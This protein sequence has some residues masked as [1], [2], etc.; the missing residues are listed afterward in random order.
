[1]SPKELKERTARFARDVTEFCTPLLEV[2]RAAIIADQLLRAGTAVNANYGSAQCGRSN[3]EFVA[4]LGQVVDDANESTGWLELLRDTSVVETTEQLER[5]V[6]ESLELTKIFAR[7]YN[8]AKQNQQ[9][10]KGT[11]KL[12]R[13]GGKKPMSR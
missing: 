8:T 11:E 13:A 10:R 1:M 12:R 5:L 9:L 3:D 7:S 4:K 2:R 6:Q